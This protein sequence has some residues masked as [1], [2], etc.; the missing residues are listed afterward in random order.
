MLEHAGAENP[1]DSPNNIMKSWRWDQYLPKN[2][3]WEFGNMGPISSQKHHTYFESL[4][5]RNFETKKPKTP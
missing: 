2:M 5:P 1:D 3:K 4:K